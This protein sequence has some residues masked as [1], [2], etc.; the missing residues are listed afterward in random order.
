MIELVEQHG[1]KWKEI[2]SLIETRLPGRKIA[3]VRNAFLR[4]VLGQRMAEDGTAQNKCKKC[5]QPKLGHV[6]GGHDFGNLQSIVR[7]SCKTN[8]K[9]RNKVGKGPSFSIHGT[10]DTP[11]S[12]ASSSKPPMS[13]T[14]SAMSMSEGSVDPSSILESEDEFVDDD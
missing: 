7:R 10:T 8:Y 9:A 14:A 2:E 4:M 12:P 11:M 6:C 1:T 5:G 3:S 13:S